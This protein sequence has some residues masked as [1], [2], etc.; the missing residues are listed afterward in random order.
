[1][2]IQ[3]RNLILVANA[4]A[5][6]LAEGSIR[7]LVRREGLGVAGVQDRGMLP[8]GFP[9]NTGELPTS[10]EIGRVCSPTQSAPG[11]WSMRGAPWEANNPQREKPVTKGDR[12]WQLRVEEQSYE[13]ILPMKVENRR[14]PATGGHGI[15]W[16]EGG[17]R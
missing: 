1:M 2:R 13:P 17:N 11:P 3:L 15:H 14:A 7:T 10:G 4:D 6:S 12:R 5:V 8:K 9:A 16:R